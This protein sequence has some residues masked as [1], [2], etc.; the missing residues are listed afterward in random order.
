MIGYTLSTN[1]KEVFS[2]LFYMP[3]YKQMFNRKYGFNVNE[4]HSLADIAKTTGI[5]K[6]ILQ[7]VYN[8]GVGAWKT[9]IDLKIN[10]IY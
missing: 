3:T 2:S 1:N 10:L 7:K 8:R 5:K 6:S 9:N 4:S